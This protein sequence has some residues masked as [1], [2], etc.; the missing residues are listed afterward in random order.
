MGNP[1]WRIALFHIL[2]EHHAG[3]VGA[4]TLSIAAAIIAEAALYL[5]WPR[6]QPPAPS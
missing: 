2:A 6:P 1:R 5:P 3:A 4:A